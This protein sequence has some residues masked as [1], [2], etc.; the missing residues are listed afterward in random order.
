MLKKKI[1][2][3][4]VI[5]NVLRKMAL[6][7]M[8]VREE[9]GERREERAKKRERSPIDSMS[10]SLKCKPLYPTHIIYNSQNIFPV[11]HLALPASIYP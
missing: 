7:P 10:H 8:G 1:H 9:R 2:K 3:L 11:E 4:E 5:L 6:V